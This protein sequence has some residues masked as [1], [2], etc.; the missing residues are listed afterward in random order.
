MRIIKIDIMDISNKKFVISTHCLT[1]GPSQA[2]KDYIQKN[3]AEYLLFISHPLNN[4]SDPDS[5]CEI[6]TGGKFKKKI[7]KRRCKNFIL[8]CLFDILLTIF[9][10]IKSG[11]R[12]DV[13]VGSDNLNALSGVI[14]KKIGM[15]KK[16]VYYSIDYFPKRF[17]N[18][19]LNYIYYKVDKFCVKYSDETWNLSDKM[20]EAR[21][22]KERMAGK[23]YNRQKVVPV[24]VWFDRVNRKDISE[25][26]KNQL[27]FVGHLAKE[28]GV[29]L[30]IRAVPKI[31]KN[32]PNF[33]FLIIG[34]G[35]EYGNLKN[36]VANL[37]LDYCIKFTGWIKDRLE[38]ENKM[39][40]GA[41]GIAPFN[42][43]ILDEK[44]Y[45]ADPAKIKDY[46]LMGMPVIL[47][48][49]PVSA[50]KIEEFGSGVV[51]QYNED[52]LAGAVINVIGDE[53][54]LKTFREKAEAYVKNYN[55][56]FI[57]E[58]NLRR[59]LNN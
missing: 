17:E 57:F 56:N 9:W 43:N 24:G 2:L 22:K 15:V 18:A 54:R 19:F 35:E 42:T 46:M 44:V 12:I 34:G 7:V 33:T 47:T 52:S 45:N 32:I 58:N 6:A 25:I 49:A 50:R 13:F 11:K 55:W 27:I 21:E 8:K 10:T 51:I 31:L 23:K 30:V 29:D 26:N 37:G 38:L 39:L 16:V 41:A 48:D 3:K 14:L 20:A 5:F 4:E 53:N 36:L 1:Y 40:Y 59:V 28:M